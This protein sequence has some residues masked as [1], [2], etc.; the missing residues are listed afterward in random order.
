MITFFYSHFLIPAY[1]LVWAN[2]VLN[3][4]DAE[5]RRCCWLILIYQFRAAHGRVYYRAAIHM[6]N[7]SP[8]GFRM[9]PINLRSSTVSVAFPPFS[10]PIS[11]S[12]TKRE[13]PSFFFHLEQK[14]DCDQYRGT[15]PPL[16]WLWR[17]GT[18]SI[19]TTHT[20]GCILSLY[21]FLYAMVNFLPTTCTRFTQQK[22][23]EA[24]KKKRKTKL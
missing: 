17:K 6:G 13:S 10:F 1:R 3:D 8:I 15:I 20:L 2:L 12:N 18:G 9:R 4:D 21:T 11:I 23:I 19:R 14:R 16:L 5:R 7:L 22:S 24:K